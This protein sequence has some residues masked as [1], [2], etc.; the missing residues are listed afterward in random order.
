MNA[1]SSALSSHP[2]LAALPIRLLAGTA[3]V[4]A[5]VSALAGM[6][7]TLAMLQ[8]PA[9]A[10]PQQQGVAAPPPPADTPTLHEVMRG[11]EDPPGEPAP[12][13]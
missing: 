11:R 7:L 9:T 12:T 2:A 8:P 1:V 6:L 10:A 13:F 3:L 5:L 4:S